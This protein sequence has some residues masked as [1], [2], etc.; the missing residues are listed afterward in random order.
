[1]ASEYSLEGKPEPFQRAIF[2]E[3]LQGILRAGGG[4]SAT[5]WGERGDAELIELDQQD[6]R[7]GK[8]FSDRNH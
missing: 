6:E 5:R 3:R 1:M 2:P 4:E 8:Y 7:S